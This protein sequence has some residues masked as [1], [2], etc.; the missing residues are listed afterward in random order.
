MKVY[1]VMCHYEYGIDTIW[2]TEE[3]ARK[4]LDSH[5]KYTFVPKEKYCNE[6]WRDELGYEYYIEEHELREQ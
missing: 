5:Q 2:A 4:Y 1:V 6:F 3:A